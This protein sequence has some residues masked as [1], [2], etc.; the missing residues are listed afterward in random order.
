MASLDC[1]NVSSFKGGKPK[2]RG[3]NLECHARDQSKSLEAYNLAQVAWNTFSAQVKVKGGFLSLNFHKSGTAGK[4]VICWNGRIGKLVLDLT[5]ALPPPVQWELWCYIYYKTD[6]RKTLQFAT[7][8]ISI[9]TWIL[10]RTWRVTRL[11]M[12]HKSVRN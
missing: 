1:S 12:T 2:A 9:A 3:A 11:T 10:E 5:I 8:P 4:L 6:V 7:I